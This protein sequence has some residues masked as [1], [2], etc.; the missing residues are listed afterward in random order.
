MLPH[1]KV[2]TRLGLSK[3]HGIGVFA[4]ADIDKGTHLFE[5]DNTKMV[6]ISTTELEKVPIK[7]KLLYQDFCVLNDNK[8][9][10][11]CPENFNQLTMAWYMNHSDQPNVE[12]D[13]EYNF[14]SIR[15][16]KD[17]EELTINYNHFKE[18]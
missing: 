13:N 14:S 15:S 6:W 17:G 18:I 9:M 7:I 3:I 5:F 8:T 4:I 16:I 11:G 10:Y 1:Y 12:A 2:Y